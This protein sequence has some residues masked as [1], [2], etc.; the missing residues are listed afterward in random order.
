LWLGYTY[1]AGQSVDAFLTP[2]VRADLEWAEWLLQPELI[3]AVPLALDGPKASST[4]SVRGGR[5]FGAFSALVGVST[6]WSPQGAPQWQVL[7]SLELGYAFDQLK[8]RAGLLTLHAMAPAHVTVDWNNFEL[9]YIAPLGAIAGYR[10]AISPSLTLRLHGFGFALFN[11]VRGM[12][13]ASIEL[14]G[15]L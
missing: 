15:E 13:T 6:N 9:G 14:P 11:S 2:Q 7:P 12:V 1:L 5:R 4:L 10:F 3:V 8:V